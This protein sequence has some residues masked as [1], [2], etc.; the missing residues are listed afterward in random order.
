MVSYGFAI[1]EDTISLDDDVL[2]TTHRIVYALTY[3]DEQANRKYTGKA[4]IDDVTLEL[5]FDSLE[6]KRNRLEYYHSEAI[7]TVDT[8]VLNSADEEEATRQLAKMK[9][10]LVSEQDML[11]DMSN[12]LDSVLAYDAD[13]PYCLRIDDIFYI[14]DNDDQLI[15]GRPQDEVVLLATI[16]GTAFIN[17]VD[18]TD[19]EAYVPAVN[20]WFIPPEASEA[21]RHLVVPMKSLDGIRSVRRQ[22]YSE[23]D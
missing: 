7:D 18:E 10:H 13:A 1:D 2:A 4:H 17:G 8:I 23:D 6:A 9:I 3:V 11:S 12:Y 14:M 16:T 21:P 15:P 20:A 5:P 22:V 19:A